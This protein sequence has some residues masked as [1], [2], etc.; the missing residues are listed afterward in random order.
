M[1]LEQIENNI[2]ELV[3]NLDKENFIYDFLLAYGLPKS[4]INRLK[5]GDYNKSKNDGE[6]IWAKKIYFKTVLE[7]EDVHDVIDDIS[8]TN[9]IEK[10]KIRFIIVTDFKTFLSKDIKTSDTLDVELSK[11]FESLNFFLPLMGREKITIDKENVVDI[12]AANKM[13]KLFDVLIRDNINFYQDNKKRLE[14][15][16]FFTKVLF[17]YF[18]EDSDIFE[19][20][21]F[22][23]TIISYSDENGDNLNVL[24][25]KIFQ[26]LNLKKK[27]NV[28]SYLTKF[29][30]VNGSL[31]KNNYDVPKFS[32]ESRKLLI[33]LG[34]L[35]WS[36]INPDILG[37]MMQSVVN[38]ELRNELGMHYTS[39]KNILKLIKPLF[40]D[41][42]NDEFFLNKE[43]SSKLK[44]LLKKI[45]TIKVFDPA[46][47][48]GNFL[49][50]SF[51]EL[52]KLELEIYKQLKIL[53]KNEWLIVKSNIS[54][55]QFYGIEIDNYAHELAKVSLYIAEHQINLLFKEIF[56]ETKPSLPLKTIDNI[57]ND[58]ALRI[59]WDK[60]CKRDHKSNIYVIGNPPYLGYKGRNQDQNKDLEN[61]FRDI[62][63]V[64]RIDYIGCWFKLATDYSFNFSNIKFAFV[65]TNSITQGEQ[66]NFL[67]PYILNKNLEIFFAYQTFNWTN[68]AKGKAGVSCVIIGL[69]NLENKQK[70]LF[71]EAN[72]IKVKNINP[73]LLEGKNIILTPRKNSISSF[74]EM[75]T[76]S[77]PIDGGNLILDNN[78]ANELFK[79]Y[80][81]ASD[82]IKPYIGGNDFL[83]GAKRFCLWIDDKQLK[84]AL[85]IKEI[86][87]RIEKCKIW[88]KN[89]GRDAQKYASSAHKFVYKKYRD[90]DC[91]ILPMTT[92]ERRV[93]LPIGYQKSGTVVSN[94]V[95]TIYNPEIYIFGILSSKMHI[96]W[97]KTF[98]GRM[99]NDI[100][101]SVNLIYNTFPFPKINDSKKKIITDLVFE[102]IDEREKYSNLSM[103]DLY[104][105]D[106]MPK[107]LINVHENL[108]NEIDKVYHL[109]GFQNDNKRI[110]HL[111]SL[112]HEEYL[113]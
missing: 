6:I 106:K 99:R 95:F 3:S 84:E 50:I 46:C 18:A 47:G 81:N 43:N 64:K 40:L 98:S 58:N 29:P 48:S 52:C 65:S 66:V 82:F 37:S 20:R 13:S 68:N 88:R 25:E 49:I 38:Q 54:L 79:K 78:E 4:S 86:K 77:S 60:L 22:T 33:E 53:D 69:R 55:S 62:G 57:C 12:K 56:G 107:K 27:E 42:L 89:S 10:Q 51:K 15:N 102:I 93:Y 92:S 76:G 32:K 14:L 103:Q 1:N 90:A 94:G 96:L 71:N 72:I 21:L 63:Q 26:I 35:D 39:V 11:L 101:Y 61:I 87:N 109:K 75:H 70:T 34:D 17:C 59:D 30:Y 113:I 31:F 24:I 7:N 5:K 41:D 8:K 67:W 45:Y 111:L 73:Y 23:N 2:K 100:R 16:I 9:E 97:M 74:P 91:L 19:K 110:E 36:S 112:Y 104:D 105:P 108:D 85:E 83:I 28:Q 44:K 80:K